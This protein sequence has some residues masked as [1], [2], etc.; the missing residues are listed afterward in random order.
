M[1]LFTKVML[2]LFI[3]NILPKD[4]RLAKPSQY[5]LLEPLKQP[6]G[7]TLIY[8]TSFIQMP[9]V[10]KTSP[11]KAWKVKAELE[12]QTLRQTPLG[13]LKKLTFKNIIDNSQQLNNFLTVNYWTLKNE[14]NIIQYQNLT[15]AERHFV[16][17]ILQ[18]LH[19]D[20]PAT[21]LPKDAPHWQKY[22]EYDGKKVTMNYTQL[23][24]EH[25]IFRKYMSKQQPLVY[26][27]T[28]EGLYKNYYIS[29]IS[30]YFHQSKSTELDRQ[31]A[32]I[33]VTLAYY[34]HQNS[35][36]MTEK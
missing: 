28:Y 4:Q 29:R 27:A 9:I 22:E 15:D 12:L 8:K 11:Q 30:A 13:F 24:A 20:P 1:N 16:E 23:D 19:F 31:A 21:A 7:R 17:K 18:A 34:G 3:S 36:Q 25:Q 5:I 14:E 33:A 10:E 2:L 32:E 26:Y 35:P 6:L